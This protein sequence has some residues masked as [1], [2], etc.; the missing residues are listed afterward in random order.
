[1][2]VW[3]DKCYC[4][5]ATFESL[6]AQAKRDDLTLPQLA[7]QVGCGLRCGWCVAYLRRALQTGET[8]FDTLIPKELLE[9]PEV[10]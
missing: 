6:V 10:E 5:D 1:M 2:K 3:I 9:L 7:V 8:G 4:I